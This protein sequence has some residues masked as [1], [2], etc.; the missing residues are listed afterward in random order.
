M[1]DFIAFCGLDCEN[2][3]ARIATVQNDDALR[4]KVAAEW[5]ALNGVTITPDMIHCAGC[6]IDGPKTA[7]CDHLCPIR[8]C[9]LAKGVQ[10]CG[11]CGE[12][13]VCEK[14]GAI[15]KNS[16]DARRNLIS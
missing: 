4:R 6:R 10:T 11:D 2:C 15:L 5:S 12:W 16:P 8:R 9:A 1:K 3:E 13:T 14:L 7:Y